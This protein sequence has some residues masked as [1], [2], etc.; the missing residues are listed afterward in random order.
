MLWWLLGYEEEPEPEVLTEE[1]EEKS[2]SSQL[3]KN[4][5]E[6]SDEKVDKLLRII[7]KLNNRKV[8][9]KDESGD[10]NVKK[11]KK[12]KSYKEAVEGKKVAFKP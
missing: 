6:L 9:K 12:K 2:K 10:E 4:I 3:L 1:L 8:K 7:D 5:E 11:S